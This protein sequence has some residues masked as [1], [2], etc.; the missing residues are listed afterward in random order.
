MRTLSG[1]ITEVNGQIQGEIAKLNSL[2]DQVAGGWSGQAATAYHNLQ[3][4]WNDDAKQLNDVL[5]QIRD[6]IDATA[7]GYA[8][9]EEDQRSSISGVTGA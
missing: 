2:I 4:K 7:K 6:A 9:T 5:N 1:R 8:Q 3:T